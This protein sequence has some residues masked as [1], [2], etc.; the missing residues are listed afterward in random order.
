MGLKKNSKVTPEFNMSSLTDIIFLLL[1]FFMLT[2]SMVIPNALN[3]Q[4]PGKKRSST[5]SNSSPASITIEANRKVYLNGANVSMRELE[6]RIRDLKRSKGSNAV[7]S[8][9][10]AGKANNEDLVRV[11]DIA[12]R[13]EVK[14]SLNSPR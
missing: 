8:V 4:L 11:L 6:R 14:A 5:I 7:I 9:T 3:L 12:Y 2:S 13:Y 1:I 10:P